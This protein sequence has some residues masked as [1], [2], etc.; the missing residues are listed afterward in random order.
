MFQFNTSLAIDRH[1]ETT[2]APL[3]AT[4]IANQAV[5][6]ENEKTGAKVMAYTAE[7]TRNNRRLHVTFNNGSLEIG[8]RLL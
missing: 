3:I 6:L 4:I 1:N 5:Y 7:A 8:S 2:D